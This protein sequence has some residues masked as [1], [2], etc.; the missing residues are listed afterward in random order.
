MRRAPADLRPTATIA[1]DAPSR[2]RILIV[3]PE[4]P[5]PPTWGFALRVYH[6]SRELARN[7][8]VSLLT[9]DMGDPTRD[10]GHL[11]SL[12]TVHSVPAPSIGRR[13]AQLLSLLSRESFH[14]SRLRSESMQRALNEITAREQF[15]VIQV[16]SSQMFGFEFPAGPA[17][18]LDE[19]NIEH[20]LLARVAASERSL[21]RR[22]YHGLE[23][24]KVLREELAAWSRATGCVVTSPDD[25]RRL[26]EAVPDA[27]TAVVANG[28]DLDYFAPVPAAV[29]HR[30]L[31]FVG[32]INYRPN[33]DAV[34]HCA[35]EILP[36][37][38][39]RVPG[40]RLTVVGQG[41]P[42]AVRRLDGP[43]VCVPGA[44]PD[45]RPFLA[46]ASVVVV[47]LRMGGGTRLKVLEALAMGKAVVSTS[48]GCEGIDVEDGR[49]LL[50]ADDAGAFAAQVVRLLGDE[51]LARRLGMAGRRLVEARYGWAS[52][53]G[54]LESFHTELVATHSGGAR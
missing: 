32:S 2:L 8:D 26:H 5:A 51:E 30:S 41:A 17:L 43:A 19:H 20:D 40:A 14:L 52:V 22:L 35:E 29:D 47:P 50:I 11:A 45:V 46:A 16:E 10:W 9:Y 39:R 27:R 6:L 36:L 21:P 23:Q 28:V 44:V 54:Q 3:C 25:R 53:A 34:L 4:P 24:R 31:V 37:V 7:H 12:F 42:R 18:V 15:D 1:V 13:R 49:H 48:I 38:R 33:T